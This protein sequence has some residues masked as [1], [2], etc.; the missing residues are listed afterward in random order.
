MATTSAVGVRKFKN[1]KGCTLCVFNGYRLYKDGIMSVTLEDCDKNKADLER[2]LSEGFVEEVSVDT[3]P[4]PYMQERTPDVLDQ[5][6]EPDEDNLFVQRKQPD[7]F[8][9]KSPVKA[10]VEEEVADN[11][12]EKKAES[13]VKKEKGKGK[14]STVQDEAPKVDIAAGETIPDN[15]IDGKPVVMQD[16]ER[17]VFDG[18]EGT[19]RTTTCVSHIGNWRDAAVVV[20]EMKDITELDR[21]IK[22]DTR[23]TVVKA[24][25]ER[26]KELVSAGNV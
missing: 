24:A 10:K 1:L 20:Q 6:E 14:K 3:K 4:E 22:N 8:S 18:F 26:K 21:I 15:V 19:E 7:I 11:K 2:L 13:K 25:E 23:A 5:E 17:Q 9:L 16:T 12:I